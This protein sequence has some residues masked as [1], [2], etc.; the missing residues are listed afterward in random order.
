MIHLP[1]SRELS[2]LLAF[3][4]TPLGQLLVYVF[5]NGET[6]VDTLIYKPGRPFCLKTMTYSTYQGVLYVC[7]GL[8]HP[9]Y[10]F[11]L[12]EDALA[13]FNDRVQLIYDQKQQLSASYS[14]ASGSCYQQ[15]VEQAKLENPAI[16]RSLFSFEVLEWPVTTYTP[17]YLTEL[18]QVDMEK[19]NE[20]LQ[21]AS[22][23]E[24]GKQP[25]L[26]RTQAVAPFANRLWCFG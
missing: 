20:T 13:K 21:K 10:R 8:N 3:E 9:L 26:L 5:Y 22:E 15:V 18:L 12:D 1:Y 2:L 4:R 16:L 17:Q 25:I 23:E 24:E 14:L 7:L 11:K 6:L 19:V